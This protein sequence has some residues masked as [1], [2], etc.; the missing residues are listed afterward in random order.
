MITLRNEWIHAILQLEGNGRVK[1]AFN[2]IIY[3]LLHIILLIIQ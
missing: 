1:V 2:L 3:Y